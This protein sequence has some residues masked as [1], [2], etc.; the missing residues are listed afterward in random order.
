[1]VIIIRKISIHQSM[2]L[3]YAGFFNK[4]KNVDDFVIF[5][6]LLYSKSYYFNRNRIKTANGV[7]MLTV[8]L[9]KDSGKKIFERK[10]NEIEIDTTQ[11]WQQSHFA[12]M[13]ASYNKSD[14]FDNYKRFFKDIYSKNWNK[15][16]DIN[17]ETIMHLKK[18]LNIQTHI[19]FDS[20]LPLDHISTHPTQRIIDICNELN[21]DV[22][23][24]GISGK[25]YLDV[26]L[27]EKNNIT[28]EFQQYS[29]I[30][31]KQL[32]GTFVPNLS[33]VDL[34]YNMGEKASKLI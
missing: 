16:R 3:P 22:Y 1:M 30:I 25:D 4:M 24:S 7:L 15:L 18:E 27:F 28:L 11:N 29:P 12:S 6:E 34:L 17:I 9:K 31:Y 2:Y 26:S 32:Y 20:D 14:Y 33:I 13:Q 23:L 8:P 10:I 21:A 5:D 19:L